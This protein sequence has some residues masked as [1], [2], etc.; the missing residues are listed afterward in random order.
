MR[1]LFKN[2]G[3]APFRKLIERRHGVFR[4]TIAALTRAV[5]RAAKYSRSAKATS[6]Q[7]AYAGDWRR[8]CD[9][10]ASTGVQT[11]PSALE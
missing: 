5:A 11:L 7:V 4:Q 2:V 6:T 1:R 8:F 3:L 9:W 10:A